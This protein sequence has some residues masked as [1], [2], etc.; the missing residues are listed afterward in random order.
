MYCLGMNYRLFATTPNG[1]NGLSTPAIGNG[2]KWWT[3]VV[4]EATI[5]RTQNSATWPAGVGQKQM[6]H[7]VKDRE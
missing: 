4:H 5:Q 2:L 1:S 3:G 7:H 6:Q